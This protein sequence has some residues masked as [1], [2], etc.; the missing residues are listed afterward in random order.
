MSGNRGYKRGHH[1]RH[2]NDKP[3]ALVGEKG[4]E[5]LK[6]IDENNAVIKAFRGYA[7]EL[8][9]KHDRYERIVKISRDITIESKRIIFLLHNIDKEN[10][11]DAILQEAESRLQ[12]LV[13]NHFSYIAVE[14]ITQDTYQFLRAYTGGLQEFIEALT[15]YQYLK[16]NA[17]E[18]W[19][20]IE[21]QFIYD[22]PD[23]VDSSCSL[24]TI[25][26]QMKTPLPAVEY[27]LGIADLTGE[28]MRKCINN[29]GSG[30]IDDCFRTCNFVRD[31]YKGFLVVGGAQGYKEIGRKIYV[32]KQS[33]YK[34]EMVCYNIIVRGS[35]IPKHMLA[36]VV[37]TSGSDMTQ[38]EDE[39][40]Y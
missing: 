31:L 17:I 38:D 39:G 34:M 4:R 21:K 26:K 10:K 28:L 24:V 14:L 16:N 18:H 22:V 8:D 5:I 19:S 30:N 20:H 15:F 32:L 37:T 6:E 7:V 36:A 33:L 27:I 13:T 35:E 3:K 23:A 12:V 1:N 2:R 40:Y 11:R 25:T 29:L 9:N